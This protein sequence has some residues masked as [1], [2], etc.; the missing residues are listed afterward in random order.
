MRTLISA[1]LLLVLAAGCAPIRRL[2]EFDAAIASA[3]AGPF[4]PP[5]LLDEAQAAGMVRF[6]TI[7]TT[8]DSSTDWR[9]KARELWGR[10]LQFRPDAVL[11]LDRIR[12][13]I[14]GDVGVNVK[15]VAFA[16]RRTVDGPLPPTAVDLSMVKVVADRDGSWRAV[17]PT[18]TGD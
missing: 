10:L 14:S 12:D 7:E 3:P 16:L 4:S 6:A 2:P 11:Y 5:I 9:Y 17:W 13:D 18:S 8:R 15:V 1:A